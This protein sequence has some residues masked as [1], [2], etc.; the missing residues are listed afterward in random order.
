LTIITVNV[1]NSN[2]NIND[3]STETTPP[4]TPTPVA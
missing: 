1:I 3:I 4:W 2:I